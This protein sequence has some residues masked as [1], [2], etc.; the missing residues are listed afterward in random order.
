MTSEWESWKLPTWGLGGGV[1]GTQKGRQAGCRGSRAGVLGISP[2]RALR[3]EGAG[4]PKQSQKPGLGRRQGSALASLFPLLGLARQSP[5]LSI[6]SSGVA[7]VNQSSPSSWP[8]GDPAP[9]FCP[10][11]AH[12]HLP[13]SSSR[14]L[15]TAWRGST[16][17]SCQESSSLL[18][19]LVVSLSRL[20]LL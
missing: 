14:R 3:G 1:G 16:L 9:I 10:L 19:T 12:H 6:H 13:G 11:H 18:C 15:G 4:H 8:P 5:S 2:P 20:P 17:G 7:R